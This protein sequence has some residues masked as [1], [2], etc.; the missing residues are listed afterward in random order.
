MSNGVCLSAVFLPVSSADILAA[1]VCFPIR[2]KEKSSLY[3]DS[4]FSLVI[5]GKNK[6]KK[7]TA[8]EDETKRGS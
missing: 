5:S 4:H 1:G 6:N 7:Q 8:V 3:H 2:R